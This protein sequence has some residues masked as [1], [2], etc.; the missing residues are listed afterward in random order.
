[1]LGQRTSAD[2][3]HVVLVVRGRSHGLIGP[4]PRL[5]ILERIGHRIEERFAVHGG[6]N[7]RHPWICTLMQTNG[8]RRSTRMQ[9]LAAEVLAVR[10]LHPHGWT[11]C[12][13]RSLPLTRSGGCEPHVPGRTGIRLHNRRAVYRR[14]VCR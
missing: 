5:I 6:V 4:C 8:L 3:L 7:F 1:M 9:H 14:G 13:S 11:D 10:R 12:L 2:R